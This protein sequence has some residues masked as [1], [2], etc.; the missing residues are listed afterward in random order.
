MCFAYNAYRDLKIFVTILS[1]SRT[2]HSIDL[3]VSFVLYRMVQQEQVLG[4]I[5]NRNRTLLKQHSGR[6][7]N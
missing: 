3:I 4:E 1:L 6:R 7:E 5:M 2:K